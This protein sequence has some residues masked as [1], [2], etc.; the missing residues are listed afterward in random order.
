MKINKRER[1]TKEK[2]AFKR[3]DEGVYPDEA[4]FLIGRIAKKNI[5]VNEP[6]TW[7]KI[8]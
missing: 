2:I 3:S 8:F 7:D 5:E 6:I 4:E 1:L